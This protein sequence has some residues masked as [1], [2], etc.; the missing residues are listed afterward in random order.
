MYALPAYTEKHRHN[1]RLPDLLMSPLGLHL[2]ARFIKSQQTL[3]GARASISHS[4][5]GWILFVNRRN[6]LLCHSSFLPGFSLVI[7]ETY[8]K[9]LMSWL[10]YRCLRVVKLDF[11]TARSNSHLFLQI[12]SIIRQDLFPGPRTWSIEQ[13]YS[14]L[15]VQF[16]E[17]TWECE[18][19]NGDNTINDKWW[20]VVLGS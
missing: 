15:W 17:L 20:E 3:W 6:I 7:L 14:I 2:V 10:I 8:Q 4:L 1:W 13:T 16:N 18:H 19:V 9:F 5:F 11:L 12:I